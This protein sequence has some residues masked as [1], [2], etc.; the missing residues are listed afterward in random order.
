[1]TIRRPFSVAVALVL[2]AFGGRTAQAQDPVRLPE[3]VI[4]AQPGPHAMTGIVRDTSLFLIEGAEV[5]IPKLQRR[6]LT[7]PDG[8]FRFEPRQG[9]V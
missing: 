4:R 7:R 1:M 5:S 3:V 8:S 2:V 9:H 6:T